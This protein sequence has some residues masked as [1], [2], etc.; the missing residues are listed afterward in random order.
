M[1]YQVPSHLVQEVLRHI[2]RNDNHPY[3]DVIVKAHNGALIFRY[4]NGRWIGARN[5]VAALL[6]L[7]SI[8]SPVFQLD[9]TDQTDR[10]MFW[11]HWSDTLADYQN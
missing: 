10:A 9:M 3:R 11:L 8:N 7:D 4:M 5:V 1:I 2:D 6:A